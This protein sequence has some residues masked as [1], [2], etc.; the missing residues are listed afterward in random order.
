MS[1]SAQ[2]TLKQLQEIIANKKNTD[3]GAREV[4]E[5]LEDGEE[6]LDA[7]NSS[8]VLNTIV[9]AINHKF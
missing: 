3:N 5:Q 6:V 2:L 9:N 7:V 1:P 8:S 4:Q